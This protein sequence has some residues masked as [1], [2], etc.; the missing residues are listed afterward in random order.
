MVKDTV[1]P[2]KDE[3]LAQFVVGSHTRSHPDFRAEED[4]VQITTAIDEDVGR[5]FL[6][7][8]LEL[9]PDHPSRRTTEIHY[10]FQRTY[11]TKT[12]ST[13]SR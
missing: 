7:C 11:Q 3:M 9:I 2:V 10:V 13:R 6:Q 8:R 4:E 5:L 1:D 12:P